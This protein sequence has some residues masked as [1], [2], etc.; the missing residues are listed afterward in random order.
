VNIEVTMSDMLKRQLFEQFIF[1]TEEEVNTSLETAGSPF[2]VVI[3]GLNSKSE[4]DQNI[5]LITLEQHAYLKKYPL[6]PLGVD[7][8]YNYR[9][10]RVPP[11]IKVDEGSSTS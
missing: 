1:K 2:R 7:Y 3:K 4:F 10:L 11:T 8:F 5:E 9:T 6:S